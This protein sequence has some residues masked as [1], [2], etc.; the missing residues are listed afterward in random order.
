VVIGS[1]GAAAQS[2]VTSLILSTG[3]FKAPV[4]GLV[5]S[6]L[7]S[8]TGWFGVLPG[9][10][11]GSGANILFNELRSF[12]LFRGLGWG[13]RSLERGWRQCFK[14]VWHKWVKGEDR[15]G[16][17]ENNND[18]GDWGWRLMRSTIEKIGWRWFGNRQSICSKEALDEWEMLS[19]SS[20]EE[21]DAKADPAVSGAFPVSATNNSVRPW[22][23][24][25][26]W[27][28][29]TI[30]ELDDDGLMA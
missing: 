27:D 20:D 24:D 10:V 29:S 7:T 8:W 13:L 5:L 9:F 23:E 14:M 21:H 12:A 22:L 30:C 2:Y 18:R 17:Y 3:D 1:T 26:D 16:D 28:N 6:L 19:Q 25:V 11:G 15:N 4:I